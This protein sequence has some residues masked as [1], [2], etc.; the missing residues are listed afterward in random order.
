ML[1]RRHLRIK[2]L[3]ELYSFFQSG[4]DDLAV[5]E[6]NIFRNLDKIYELYIFLLLF[7]RELAE[8]ER[9]FTEERPQQKFYTKNPEQSPEVFSNLSFIRSLKQDKKFSVSLLKTRLN[10]QEDHEWVKTIFI[11]IR[12]SDEYINA[13]IKSPADEINF[14]T[15][16]LEKMILGQEDFQNMLEEKNIQWTEEFE[17]VCSCIHRTITDSVNRKSLQLM[18]LFRDEKDDKDFVRDLFLKTIL[19]S[20]KY[21]AMIAEKTFNW[22]ADRIA[23]MDILLMKMALAEMCYFPTIPVKV[24]INEYIDISKEYST[25]KSREFINGII[26]KLAIE[27]RN[28]GTIVKTGRGLIEQ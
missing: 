6:K 3:Q 26:D 14:L 15:W 2:V 9:N 20:E 16:V 27:L 21:Q 17:F 19:N 13:S 28:K 11:R 12:K 4:S 25:P 24:S 7:F 8:Q 5:A 1:N 22:E 10:W 18:R 23:L